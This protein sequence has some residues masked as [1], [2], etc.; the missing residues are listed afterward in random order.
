MSLFRQSS[1]VHTTSQVLNSTANQLIHIPSITTVTYGN[2][3]IRYQCAKL[4]N[5]IFKT[6]DIQV[7]VDKSKNVKLND[8]LNVKCLNEILKQHFLFT[9]TVESDFIFY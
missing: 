1:E 8:I 9:Y 5:E 3:S 4:W 6:G 7:E 2:K